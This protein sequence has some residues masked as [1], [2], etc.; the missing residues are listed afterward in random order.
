M[1]GTDFDTAIRTIKK[2]SVLWEIFD[3]GNH[4]LDQTRVSK[5]RKLS[6]E[7]GISYT[8]HGP[9]C[10]LNLATLS[11]E[12]SELA[13]KRLKR[14]LGHAA[15]LE[16]KT[17]VLHPGTHGA[18]SWVHPGEDWN[19]NRSRMEELEKLARRLKVPV[20]IE[21]ISAGLAI[22]RRAEDFLRFYR[23]WP[24][25][26][27]ICLDIGHSHIAKQGDN[28]F[29]KLGDRL[30]HVHAHDNKADMDKHLAIGRG[31]IQWK[32]TIASLLD[33]GYDGRIVIESVRGPFASLKR[34]RALLRSFQ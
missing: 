34:I 19:V 8:V 26:P 2:N 18:L 29:R 14:S 11:E 1:L 33:T 10:D 32:K 13:S 23:E 17:W 15:S 6:S 28:Y 24:S 5:L 21:N 3:D 30:G 25:A 27:N 16:A 7:K 20:A 9:I 4:T 12:A 31:T 22:L